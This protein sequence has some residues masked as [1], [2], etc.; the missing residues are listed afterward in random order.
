MVSSSGSCTCTAKAQPYFLSS[1]EVVV[2]VGVA[3]VTLC[4]T[5]ATP[6]IKTLLMDQ[7]GV[8]VE[9]NLLHVVLRNARI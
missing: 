6:L 8:Y 3:R 4:H 7:G 1:T 9:I 2:Q 5:L